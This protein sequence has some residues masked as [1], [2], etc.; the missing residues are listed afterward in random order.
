[1]PELY[2]EDFEPNQVFELGTHTVSEE[3]IVEFARRWDPQPFHVDPAAARDTVFGGLI[4]SGGHTVAIWV[5]LYVESVLLGGGGRGSPGIDE[6]R[7]HAPVRPGDNL[8]ARLIVLDATPSSRQPG[9]GTVRSRAE[10]VNQEGATVMSM[11]HYAHFAR[12]S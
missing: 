3:E 8:R 5:R 9:R 1:M 4:A 11:L 10:M 6:L 2:F 12:R 7:W